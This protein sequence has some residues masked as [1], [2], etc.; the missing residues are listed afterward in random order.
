MCTRKCSKYDFH[1]ILSQKKFFKNHKFWLKI[2]FWA[3]KRLFFHRA[4]Q[5]KATKPLFSENS[6]FSAS[7]SKNRLS[8]KVEEKSYGDLKKLVPKKFLQSHLFRLW[9]VVCVRYVTSLALWK[10][11]WGSFWYRES[12]KTIHKRWKVVKHFQ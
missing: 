10:G 4:K 7:S 3:K 9:Y 12:E 2:T 1:Y 8:K 11:F 5:R 6:A